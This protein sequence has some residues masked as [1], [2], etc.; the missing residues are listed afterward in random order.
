MAVTVANVPLAVA[1]GNGVP[2]KRGASVWIAT[3]PPVLR[4]RKIAGISVDGGPQS[5]NLVVYFDATLVDSTPYG[6]RN[7][8]E[9]VRPKLLY[10]GATM[11]IIWS[12][13]T[14]T[15]PSATVDYELD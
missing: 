1:L 12:L 15:V 6:V 8:Q 14:G 11:R 7:Q 13:G 9:Y 4:N 10:R 5:S 2:Y 3:L